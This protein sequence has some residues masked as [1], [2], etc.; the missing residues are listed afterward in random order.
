VFCHSIDRYGFEIIALF[1]LTLFFSEL[2]ESSMVQASTFIDQIAR[3]INF[4]IDVVEK[5]E[6]SF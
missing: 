6:S 1:V 3:H 5:R 4:F 2:D